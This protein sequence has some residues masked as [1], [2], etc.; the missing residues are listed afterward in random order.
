MHATKGR[1][2][3]QPGTLEIV[4]VEFVSKDFSEL[5]Y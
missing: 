1:P 3:L 4:N 2:S 5:I